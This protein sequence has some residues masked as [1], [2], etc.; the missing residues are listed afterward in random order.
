[1][2]QLCVQ[3]EREKQ[4]EKELQVLEVANIVLF[5]YP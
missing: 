2:L 3:E 5:H 4:H 1:M